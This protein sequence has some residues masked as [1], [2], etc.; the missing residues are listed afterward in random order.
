VRRA[1]AP[2][3][4]ENV[5]PRCIAALDYWILFTVRLS[6]RP[7]PWVALHGFLSFP[8]LL[9][10]GEYRLE[11]E[12]AGERVRVR[13][14]AR[15]TQ[16]GGLLAGAAKVGTGAPTAADVGPDLEVVQVHPWAARWW[17]HRGWLV[18]PAFVR[19][20]GRL[21]SMPPSRL[22]ENLRRN[23]A[24][25]RRNGFRQ[26]PSCGVDWHRA[27]E[28][29]ES[30]ARA[31]FGSD[32]W[33]PPHHAWGRMRR[34]GRPIMIGDGSR[35]VAMAIVVSARGGDEAWLGPIGVANTDHVLLRAGALTAAYAAAVEEARRSGAAVFDG[36]RCS[37]RA[38]DQIAAYKMRWGLR[39][40]ADPLS[41]L[42]ALRACT[43]AG[44]RLLAAL[45]LWTLGP[46]AGL[47]RT[48]PG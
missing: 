32:A 24:R 12:H 4:L 13:C 19:Y 18:V 44:E 40:T 41:P 26:R 38:D 27:R 1:V 11:T 7:R 33:F 46:G 45:P 16:P 48:G 20:R 30:W 47:R 21:D 2:L 36:G 23:L 42:Y 17:R 31:R 14:R 9:R 8:L 10:V 43:P 39:P 25:A 3:R 28:I 5:L 6:R 15:S 35:D 34:H 22:S 37:A 29:A